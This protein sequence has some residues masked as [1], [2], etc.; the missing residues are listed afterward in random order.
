MGF[1][2]FFYGDDWDAAEAAT[3]AQDELIKALVVLEEQGG[4]DTAIN[5]TNGYRAV[6]VG[7]QEVAAEADDSDV[8]LEYLSAAGAEK[9]YRKVF[10]KAYVRTIRRSYPKYE[11]DGDELGWWPES[12]RLDPVWPRKLLAC[13]AN[14][15]GEIEGEKSVA[16]AKHF[17]KKDAQQASAKD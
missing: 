14:V 13:I 6:W 8:E 11:T 5:I 12:L 17:E 15:I 3:A 4:G 2:H 10:L 7:A 1:A 9:L 16:T